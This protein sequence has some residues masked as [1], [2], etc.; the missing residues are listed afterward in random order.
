MWILQYLPN[1]IFFTLF[2]IAIAVFLVT[3]FIRMLPQ[4]ELIQ[5]GSIA[6]ALFSIFMIGAISNN[7]AWLER[8][9]ELETKVAQ[10]EAQSATL[11]TQLV[12]ITATKTQ[13]V[14]ERGRDIVK[15][16]DREV[17]K[18]DTGCVI[19]REFVTAHNRAAEA[20]KK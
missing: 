12:E 7:N 17:V 10:A 5:A 8:V 18:Y 9:R 16:V 4:A 15:Y 20:P 2:F 13:V 1:W 3:K 11:N 19:P 14:R 6:V